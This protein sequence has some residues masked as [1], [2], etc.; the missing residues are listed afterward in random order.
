MKRGPVIRSP[1]E[2]PFQPRCGR[3]L[4]GLLVD[5]QPG[6]RCC[7][8]GQNKGRSGPPPCAGP[9]FQVPHPDAKPSA[10]RCSVEIQASGRQKDPVGRFPAWLETD[11]RRES[12]CERVESGGGDGTTHPLCAFKTKVCANYIQNILFWLSS[13][14][15][16]FLS[17]MFLF[18]SV[19]SFIYIMFFNSSLIW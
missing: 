15:N 16:V 13:R 4:P 9:G 17:E 1:R 18:P 6:R 10:G 19:I 8:L 3:K 2:R 14:F 5:G 11:R 7:F 12:V